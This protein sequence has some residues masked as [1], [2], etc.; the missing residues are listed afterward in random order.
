MDTIKNVYGSVVEKLGY[1]KKQKKQPMKL[2]KQEYTKI[3]PSPSK[4][5]KK[6]GTKQLKLKTVEEVH[7]NKYKPVI[8]S[9][10]KKV[11]NLA[12]YQKPVV[13]PVPVKPAEPETFGQKIIKGIYSISNAINEYTKPKTKPEPKPKK[14]SQKTKKEIQELIENIKKTGVVSEN[15]KI[16][17]P[18]KTNPSYKFGQESKYAKTY[19]YQ[20]P[21]FNQE[22]LDAFPDTNKKVLH[23]LF[24][25][26]PLVTKTGRKP[27]ISEKY[28]PILQPIKK[29]KKYQNY[30]K[31]TTISENQKSSPEL[32]TH[33]KINIK[34]KPQLDQIIEDIDEEEYEEPIP[35]VRK[36][37]NLRKIQEDEEEEPTPKVRKVR[38]LR[39]I[40]EEDEEPTPKVR[41]VRNLRKIQEEDEEPTPKVRK[42]RNLRKIQEEDEE[43]TP[44]VKK[45]K[46]PAKAPKAPA[47]APKAPAKAPKAPA[48]APKAPAKAPKAPAKAP[49]APEKE[50]PPGKV[51]NP[52]TNRC[53]KADGK[54]GK[55]IKS[56]KN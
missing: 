13:K 17:P 11:V 23:Q 54:I 29:E 34:T 5:V 15:K 35:K 21:E 12:Q 37:R 2:L 38:N 53:V 42:V 52:L 33:K 3:K 44:K 9:P 36:V 19:E 41:K 27:M 4:N 51:Y 43:P 31:L 47:K 46:A 14:S 26:T 28:N 16:S 48:K 18:F 6:L 22:I 20:E 10:I 8:N 56:R 25:N 32:K 49:K 40:Q 24:P 1:N 45:T 50:C 39:K 30:Q 7:L 55:E